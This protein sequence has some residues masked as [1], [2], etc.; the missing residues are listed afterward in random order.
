MYPMYLHGP[1]GLGNW[2]S[3]VSKLICKPGHEHSHLA[4][5]L[6][7]QLE[8]KLPE[9]RLLSRLYRELFLGSL[10]GILGV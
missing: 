8:A 1:F 7:N 3:R 4:I 2:T 10:T 6:P 9:G 5:R